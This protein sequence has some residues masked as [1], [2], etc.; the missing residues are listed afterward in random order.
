MADGSIIIDTS[1]DGTGL[2]KGLEK[3]GSV[4]NTALKGVT[5]AIGAVTAGLTAAGGFAIKVGSEFEAGMSQ[6]A[7]TMGITVDEIEKGST[8][9]EK[10]KQAAKDMGANTQF[11]A[12][13]ASEALNY[14]AL[15]GYNADKAI[16]ALPNVLNLAAAGGLEL[17][18]ASDMVTDSMSALGIKTEELVGFTDELAKTSQK[19]N[20]SIAQLGEAILTV[21]GTAKDLAG[22]TVE[23]NTALGILADNGIKGAEGGTTLRNVIL[24]MVPTTDKAIKAFEQLNLETYDAQENLRPLNEIFEDFNAELGSLSQKEKTEVLNNIFNKVDLK[25]VSALMAGTA[26]SVQDLGNALTAAE[27][28]GDKISEVL[29]KVEDG[30]LQATDKTKFLEQ[31]INEVGLSEGQAKIAFEALN[32]IVGDTGSRFDELS[33]M[34]AESDGAAQAMAETMM[35]NLKGQI[36]LFQS[37][38]EGLGNEI[39]ENIDLAPKNAVESATNYIGQLTEALKNNGIPGLVQEIGTVFA[40]MLTD[41]A[42]AAPEAINAAVTVIQSFLTG[43]QDSLPEITDAAIEI[44]SSLANGIITILP[45][46]LTVAVQIITQLA[47]DLAQSAPELIPAAVD[48]IL[49]FVDGLLENIDPLLDAALGLIMGLAEGIVNALPKI[50]EAAPKI[51]TSLV[52]T[53]LDNLPEI[54]KAAVAILGALASFLVE[55]IHIMAGVIPTLFSAIVEYFRNNDWKLIGQNIIEGIKEGLMFAVDAVVTTITSVG[56]QILNA[57]KDFFGIHS[58][59]TVFAELGQNLI[60]GLIDGI[61]G[62]I[63]SVVDV[64]VSLGQNI[65]SWATTTIPEFVSNVVDFIAQLPNKIWSIFLQVISKVKEWTNNIISWVKTEIPKFVSSIIDA[66]AQLPNKLWTIFLQAIAKVKEWTNN[67]ISW[68][69]TEIPKFVSSVVD[70]IAELPGKA[71]KHLDD[72]VSKVKK[73]ASDLISTAQTEIPKFV[74]AVIDKLKEL[75]QKALEIGEQFVE[76]IWD[77]IKNMTNW[78]GEKIGGFVNDLIG[79]AED[80]AKSSSKKSSSSSRESSRSA[81]PAAYSLQPASDSGGAAPA[82]YSA[83]SAHDFDP[84]SAS[85]KLQSAVYEEV[86]A[87]GNR[88]NAESKTYN[89]E[90]QKGETV[91]NNNNPVLQF[92][93]P[94]ETPSQTAQAVKR[95]MKSIVY[96]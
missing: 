19:S 44:V 33:K 20:T 68:V 94:V 43:I 86:S 80:D 36:T 93:Q 82:A 25:A 7:A 9:F 1:V 45:E 59:S 51:I 73:W 32:S 69:K 18:Y 22:G 46:L 90:P 49:G 75:P 37:A 88:V 84:Y 76:S 89:A 34:I 63:Q 91:I 16:E 31:A 77:G 35:H 8:E 15:A 48:T 21:G 57:F 47:D 65:L 41:I 2:K 96:G 62:L 42:S 78:I 58:P 54:A 14:L 67:I 23:L 92:Y 79:G 6:V 66:I 83:F 72:F 60:Q 3:L 85:Q 61:S 56:T 71:K 64:F 74:T 4:G 26:S 70:K 53:L 39:Y 87:T 27:V 38:L 55:N 17:G 13:Q 50:A 81:S 40:Q 24:A 30:T 10:L 29:K 12:T 52:T 28:P 95:T 5:T 11:S